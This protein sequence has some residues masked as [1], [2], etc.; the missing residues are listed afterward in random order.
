MKGRH[1]SDKK[2]LN[3]NEHIYAKI[4]SRI[5][6]NPLAWPRRSSVECVFVLKVDS[7]VIYIAHQKND[8]V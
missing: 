1:L 6:F 5:Y 3:G 8:Y 4:N 7:Y 2:L